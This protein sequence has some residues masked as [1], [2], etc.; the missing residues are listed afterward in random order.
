MPTPG[1]SSSTYGFGLSNGEIL[2]ESFDRIGVRPQM[3][4]RHHLTSARNSLNL[5]LLTWVNSGAPLWKIVSG[6]IELVAN[7]AVYTLPTNLVTLTEMWYSQVNANGTGQNS[8]RIM[9]PLTRTEYAMIPNKLQPGTPTQFWYEML[10]APQVTLWQVP[11]TGAPTYV[12]NWFGLQQIQDAG[13]GSGET[14]DVVYRALEALCARLALRLFS[15]FGP[16]NPAVRQ[17]KRQE[18]KEEADTAWADFAT[19]DQEMG[20]QMIQPAIGVYGKIG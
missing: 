17:V 13:I 7:Q 6:T 3:I 19:R 1:T 18:L 15:K 12:C 4:T 20:P 10:A 8:D 9:V 14:P 2:F 11:F 5:E 16:E